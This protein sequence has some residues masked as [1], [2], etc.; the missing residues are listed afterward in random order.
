MEKLNKAAN[1]YYQELEN[2]GIKHYFSSVWF[3]VFISSLLLFCLSFTWLISC[4]FSAVPNFNW[5][6]AA[7]TAAFEGLLLYSQN[8]MR[9]K[10]E[11]SILDRGEKNYSVK[12]ETMAAYKRFLLKLFFGRNESEY[13]KF[14]EEIDKALQIHLRLVSSNV[15]AAPKFMNLIYDPDS[16]QRIYALLLAI[17]SAILAL[18][19]KF[20]SDLETL[21]QSFGELTLSRICLI[22]ISISFLLWGFSL[23]ILGL[24]IALEVFFEFISDRTEKRQFIGQVY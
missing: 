18:S 7:I 22:M 13:L 17:G 6:A 16:K 5:N 15:K 9:K 24:R 4:L 2:I 3:W 20:G 12:F 1:K 8:R 19:I 10:K 21:I 14:V 23:V 11:K